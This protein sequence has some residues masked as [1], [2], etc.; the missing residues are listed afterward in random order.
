M[1][2]PTN[3]PAKG[4]DTGYSFYYTEK[5]GERKGS[6]GNGS[7]RSREGG[8]DTKVT[9]AEESVKEDVRKETTAPLE[10][11]VQNTSPGLGDKG[12]G[13]EPR[14]KNFD[15]RKQT[16]D[17]DIYCRESLGGVDNPA[18]H[19]R[20]ES[21]Y[22]YD[23]SE[24]WVRNGSGALE[25]VNMGSRDFKH[26]H[27][28]Q[29]QHQHPP[30]YTQRYIFHPAR[31]SREDLRDLSLHGKVKTATLARF[32]SDDSSEFTP[33]H[34]IRGP[35]AN[36]SLEKHFRQQQQQEQY[37]NQIRQHYSRGFDSEREKP[38]HERRRRHRDQRY[39]YNEE[40]DLSPRKLVTTLSPRSDQARSVP[41]RRSD[42]QH[43]SM[44]RHRRYYDDT[45]PRFGSGRRN[46]YA[47]ALDGNEVVLDFAPSRSRSVAD[48]S[49][50]NGIGHSRHGRLRAGMQTTG[51][52]GRVNNAFSH[53][54]EHD[55]FVDF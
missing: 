13:G 12:K 48:L 41:R 30:A 27:Q 40:I 19:L 35:R 37:H 25:M 39:Y 54:R 38:H 28:L 50:S 8:G 49:S 34:D 7:A 52:H 31:T 3:S 42:G 18:V 4:D 9:P 1:N 32:D 45:D 17:K 33:Y 15:N 14:G 51:H 5:F 6:P 46:S 47:S 26:H 22:S 20:D 29:K 16:P 2:D 36:R 23:S 44:Q 21:P 10:N 53:S 55:K 11:T 24:L 43:N